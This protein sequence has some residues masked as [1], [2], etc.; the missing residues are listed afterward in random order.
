MPL[1]GKLIAKYSPKIVLI[2]GSILVGLGWLGASFSK[3]IVIL[4][5]TYGIIAGS[6]VGIAYGVPIGVVSKWFPDKKGLALGI[7]LSG[8]G[9]SPFVTAPI[10]KRLIDVYGVFNTF[11]LLGMIFLVLLILLSLPFKFPKENIKTNS[12]DTASISPKEMLSDSRFYILWICFTIATFVGLMIIG[13]TSPVGE[14]VVQINSKKIALFVSLFSVFNGVGRPLFGYLSD[15]LKPKNVIMFSY[16]LILI[17]SVIV[18]FF[19]QN[20]TV[21]YVI[22]FIL[23]WMNFGGWL[24]IAP[25]LTSKFFGPKYYSE[26][27]GILFTAYGVGAILGN[28]TSGIIKDVFGSYTLVAYPIAALVILGI[29]LSK[30]LN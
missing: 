30:K 3:N 2:A 20:T 26:N 11:K 29:I 1:G 7:L 6:G 18:I 25:T 21:L 15:K 10:A 27:Y 9:M 5:I 12:S 16:C 19:K 17:A 24:S 28:L 22:S 23:F 4:T 8:F 14:D 13:I